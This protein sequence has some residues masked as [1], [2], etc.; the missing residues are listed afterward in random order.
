LL[1]LGG[2]VPYLKNNA[3]F[4]SFGTLVNIIFY[5]TLFSLQSGGSVES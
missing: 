3:V 2:D 4:G 5:L 1:R